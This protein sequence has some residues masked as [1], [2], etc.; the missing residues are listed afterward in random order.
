[1]SK[2]HSAKSIPSGQKSAAERELPI[3]QMV[4]RAV[5]TT[6]MIDIIKMS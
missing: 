3:R 4:S 1:M 5:V 6:D 2:L